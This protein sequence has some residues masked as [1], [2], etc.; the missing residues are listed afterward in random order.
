MAE[1]FWYYGLSGS[2][3]TTEADKY[4]ENNKNRLFKIER[5][6]GDVFRTKYGN[7]LGYTIKDRNENIK[8]ACY[9]ADELSKKGITVVASFTTPFRSMRQLLNDVLGSRL[10]LIFVDTPLKE[11]IERDSKGLYKKALNGE[12]KNMI[13]VDIDFER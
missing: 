9:T 10:H 11:C 4:A 5:L 12:I 13:G 3:K 7:D 6:D 1:V 2:G 8:R